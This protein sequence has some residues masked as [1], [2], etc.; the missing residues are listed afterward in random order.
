MYRKDGVWTIR[1]FGI[2]VLYTSF[3]EALRDYWYYC[4]Q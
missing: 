3:S 2:E 1:V 4:Q